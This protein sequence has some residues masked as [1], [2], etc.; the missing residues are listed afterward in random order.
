[1]LVF[2]ILV[3]LATCVAASCDS[4]VLT[5]P[6]GCLGQTGIIALIIIGIVIVSVVLCMCMC[7]AGF[8]KIM[9]RGVKYCCCAPCMFCSFLT[10]RDAEYESHTGRIALIILILFSVA[11]LVTA[12]VSMAYVNVYGNRLWDDFVDAFTASAVPLLYTGPA[13]Y[14]QPT[15]NRSN[16]TWISDTEAYALSNLTLSSSINSTDVS[17]VLILFQIMVAVVSLMPLCILC[18]FIIFAKEKGTERSRRVCTKYVIFNVIVYMAVLSCAM[19][20]L[21]AP[22]AY[23]DQIL[24]GCVD[25]TTVDNV[26]FTQTTESNSEIAIN[27]TNI[28]I[29]IGDFKPPVL[30]SA[31][32]YTVAIAEIS[33]VT[34]Q[35]GASM[36]SCA[37]LC[38]E[39]AMSAA[40]GVIWENDA[41]NEFNYFVQNYT[42]LLPCSNMQELAVPTDNGQYILSVVFLG[43]G[44]FLDLVVM[45][46]LS[47][48][49]QKDHDVFFVVS[50]SPDTQA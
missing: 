31:T 21:I 23:P 4:S 46:V 45:L 43:V 3:G 6:N 35:N 44:L 11:A 36:E 25:E 19:I 9:L 20:I 32:N 22:A 16:F 8:R 27:E 14:L 18:P 12:N 10:R 48:L 28:L 41:L 29:T 39:P 33:S 47:I 24:P 38:L 15:A 26:N 37:V 17:T 49:I 40:K 34:T 1:M 42:Y 13:E 50:K 2:L 5:D 7:H 30:E